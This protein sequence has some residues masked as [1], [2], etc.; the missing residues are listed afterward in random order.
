[1]QNSYFKFRVL[2]HYVSYSLLEDKRGKLVAENKKEV[3]I[4]ILHFYVAD[5]LFVFF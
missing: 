3:G 1:M 4:A 2:A 5:Q